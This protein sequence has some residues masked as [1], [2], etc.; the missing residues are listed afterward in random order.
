MH[1]Q[2]LV[3]KG[4][5]TCWA[6]MAESMLMAMGKEP[7]PWPMRVPT[8]ILALVHVPPNILQF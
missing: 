2:M 3:A 6:D 8:I 1:F 5:V 7:A 4:M